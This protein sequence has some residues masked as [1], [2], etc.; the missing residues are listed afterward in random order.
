MCT[1]PPAD[2]LFTFRVTM[3]CY[4]DK[5]RTRADRWLPSWA[6]KYVWGSKAWRDDYIETGLYWAWKLAESKTDCV[7]AVERFQAALRACEAGGACTGLHSLANKISPG[8]AST[9]AVRNAIDAAATAPRRY[10]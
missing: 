7:L 2:I 1:T 5:Y 4:Q 9:S 3:A 6:G 10:S 8:F